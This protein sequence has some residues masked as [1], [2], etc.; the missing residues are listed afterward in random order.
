MGF[1]APVSTASKQ[2][3]NRPDVCQNGLAVWCV[4][5]IRKRKEVS[6]NGSPG[7]GIFEEVNLL[8]IS[9]LKS[10]ELCVLIFSSLLEQEEHDAA[11]EPCLGSTS[12]QV[13]CVLLRSSSL[14]SGRGPLPNPPYTCLELAHLSSK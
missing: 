11:V 6:L 9:E 10:P 13:S 4:K 3:S 14:L 2:C 8:I 12:A 5:G 1:H 7:M